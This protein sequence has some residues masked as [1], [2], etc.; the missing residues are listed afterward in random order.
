MAPLPVLVASYV[1]NVSVAIAHILYGY[2]KVFRGALCGETAVL[3]FF[4][5]ERDGV[6]MSA[7]ARARF[8]GV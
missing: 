3:L 8:S 7:T 2:S 5:G 1:C 4:G 6:C